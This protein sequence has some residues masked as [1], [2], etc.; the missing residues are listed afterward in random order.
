MTKDDDELDTFDALSLAALRVLEGLL[1]KHREID[2]RERHE[3]GREEDEHKES[4]DG[5]SKDVDCD[6]HH[7]ATS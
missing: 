3:H 7:D 4:G 5:A 6:V 1:T 2:H